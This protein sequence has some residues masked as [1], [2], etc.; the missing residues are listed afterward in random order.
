MIERAYVALQFSRF[1]D[2]C[3]EIGWELFYEA[4]DRS[5]IFS[6]DKLNNE[7]QLQPTLDTEPGK[8]EDT[9]LRFFYI[10]HIDVV[11]MDVLIQSDIEEC[12]PSYIYSSYRYKTI[13]MFLGDGK[14]QAF[15]L[16]TFTS[17]PDCGDIYAEEYD[18]YFP[19]YSEDGDPLVEH[20]LSLDLQQQ[21]MIV[22]DQ[23]YLSLLDKSFFGYLFMWLNVDDFEFVRITINYKSDG[24]HFM[25]MPEKLTL[26]C[27]E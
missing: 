19:L 7:L 23:P 16:P 21:R 26:T 15:S 17:E 12:K 13:D 1:Q 9:Y 3:G 11:H 2:V 4:Q 8:I 24:P 6:L 14:D 27:T 22:L 10:E 18:L 5:D 25:S 20:Y